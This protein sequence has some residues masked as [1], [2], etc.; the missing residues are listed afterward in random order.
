[1]HDFTQKDK[2]LFNSVNNLVPNRH[3]YLDFEKNERQK[4]SSK[5]D[6]V[7]GKLSEDNR[8]SSANAPKV[9]DNTSKLKDNRLDGIFFQKKEK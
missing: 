9:D 1:M 8:N 7:S 2:V 4:V 6:F 3:L 5:Y